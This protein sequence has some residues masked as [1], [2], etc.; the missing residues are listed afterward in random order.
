MP[1]ELLELYTPLLCE[2]EQMERVLDQ[3][4]FCEAA[5]KLYSTLTILEKDVFT[6]AKRGCKTISQTSFPFQVTRG[7]LKRIARN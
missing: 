5:E 2:M 7:E 1:A 6:L 4:E 3:T